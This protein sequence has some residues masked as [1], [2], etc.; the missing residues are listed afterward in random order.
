MMNKERSDLDVYDEAAA[1]VVELGN[2]L[3]EQSPASDK[4]EVADGLLAGAIH[5]WLFSRQPCEN[6]HCQSCE[7]ISTAEKRLILLQEQ[8]LEL[9]KS[10]DYYHTVNDQNVGHA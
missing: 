3:S 5:Y 2:Q 6:Q 7:A 8:M 9:T 1:V 4:E 10:S